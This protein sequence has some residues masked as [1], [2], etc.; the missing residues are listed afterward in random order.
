MNDGSR[1]IKGG[2]ITA[3][4]NG[5]RQR[6]RRLSETALP[7]GRMPLDLIEDYYPKEL[8]SASFPPPPGPI[9]EAI[10]RF[11]QTRLC[12]SDSTPDCLPFGSYT[13]QFLCTAVAF[14]ACNHCDNAEIAEIVEIAEITEIAEI[15]EIAD[16][17]EIAESAK[18]K[19]YNCLSS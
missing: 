18:H 3:A 6:Q 13:A 10:A 4:V 5:V 8:D 12:V 1:C 9:A 19:V 15:A 17:A 11:C 14:V 2:G 16:I 7:L